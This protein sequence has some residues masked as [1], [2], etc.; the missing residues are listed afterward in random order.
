MTPILE[1]FAKLFFLH[2]LYPLALEIA[3]RRELD[4][5]FKQ[6]S[7]KIYGDLKGAKTTAE[8]KE[9]ARRLY[10]LQKYGNSL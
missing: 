10:D 9:A 3:T 1:F 7:D 2:L 5:L 6:E 8:R 4:P